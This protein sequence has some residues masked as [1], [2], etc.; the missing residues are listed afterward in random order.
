MG[1]TSKLAFFQAVKKAGGVDAIE[2]FDT[3]IKSKAFEVG[4][5]SMCVSVYV[6]VYVYVCVRVGC[7]ILSNSLHFSLLHVPHFP[8]FLIFFP[9]FFLTPE[10]PGERGG[11]APVDGGNSHPRSH[12]RLSGGEGPTPQRR[13]GAVQREGGEGV[14]EE[15]RWLSV[16][17]LQS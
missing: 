6:Y 5:I 15:F 14:R 1:S 3:V 17:P 13:G 8:S 11:A 4:T 7:V 10:N 9:P 12:S 16:F 2:L